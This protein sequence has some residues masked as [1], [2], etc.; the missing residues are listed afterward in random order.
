MLTSHLRDL[1]KD[2]I[3]HREV[4]AVV[5]PRVEY[6]LTPKGRTLQPIMAAMAEWGERYVQAAQ[7][8]P[9]REAAE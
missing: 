1:E 9:A 3:I 6:S 7:T 8:A 4:F 2:G 5:P